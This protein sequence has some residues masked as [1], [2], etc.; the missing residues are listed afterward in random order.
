[1]MKRLA[2]LRL[3]LR[4]LA[5]LAL[6]LAVAT[7]LYLLAARFPL[8]A[9]LTQNASNSLEPGSIEVLRQL[10]GPLR[11]TVYIRE[12]DA[13]QGDLRPLIRSFVALYQRYKPD[14]ALD[15]V[16]PV[17]HPDAAQQAEIESNGEMVVEYGERREH[18]T[19]LNEQA[20]SSALLAL[21]HRKDQQLM[22]VTG[23]GERKLDGIANADLGD[24]GKRLAR[25]GFRLGAL[26]LAIAQEVPDNVHV[27]V[28]TQPQTD[29]L[30][31]ELDKLT[32][33]VE[34]GGNLFWLLDAGNLHGLERLAQQLGLVLTPGIVVDPDA[35]EMRAP[36]SWALGANYPPHPIT[37][38]F[39]LVT[40]FPYARA[41]GHEENRDWQYRTLVEA[42]PRGWVSASAANGK[43]RFDR[44]R[45]T[46]GPAAIALALQRS[47][48]EHE[49]RV[50]VSGSG[51]FLANM[52]AGNGGNL[53]LGINMVNWLSQQEQLITI[54]PRAARD[55]TLTLS[56]T[57]LAVISIG[58]VIVL[59]LLLALAGGWVW[60]RR[61]G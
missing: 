38:D 35:E 26:N 58:S 12:Q 47:S 57:Q 37:R 46:P 50:V 25:L 40:A 59:P 36:S 39:N 31:G 9:D 45:D 55:N 23:H 29:W 4:N 56:K 21:A 34:R 5:H 24:F 49:Q 22:Y 51:A 10:P 20:L 30:P 19:M 8:H 16:D 54:A 3:P 6:L 33:Y 43:P 48:H 18:L 15:F 7:A 17:Q 61:R 28:I 32:R 41:L 13:K 2:T 14:I 60:W 27:L 1:M 42:A 52:Y 44:N 11:L 53:D